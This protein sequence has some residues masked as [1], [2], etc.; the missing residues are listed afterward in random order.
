M[1]LQGLRCSGPPSQSPMIAEA[2]QADTFPESF[3]PLQNGRP[4]GVL[5]EA[6]RANDSHPCP[7]LNSPAILPSGRNTP[8]R[9]PR[10]LR[11]IIA[12]AMAFCLAPPAQSGDLDAR[13]QTFFTTH[14]ILCHDAETKKAGLDLTKLAWKPDEP[15]SSNQWVEVFDNVDKQKMPPPQK[16][17]PDAA[18]RAA[19]LQSL[20]NELRAANQNQQRTAGRVVLRRLNRFEYENTLHDLL[21]I[22]VPL[23]HFLPQDA[24]VDGFDNVAAGL[25]LSMFHM[26]QFL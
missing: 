9:E 19:F 20:G 17:R 16:K 2:A 1:N 8:P 7:P 22:N 6:N 13:A 3:P 5:V 14:C 11:S 10:M 25:H 23:Q 15:D 12:A 26:Q 18:A 24:S 4:G 21:A